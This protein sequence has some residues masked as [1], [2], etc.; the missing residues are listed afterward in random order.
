MINLGLIGSGLVSQICHLPSFVDD[1]RVKFVAISDLNQDILNKV[2]KKYSI[3]N[4]FTDYKVM[5]QKCKLDGVVLASNRNT[6]EEISEYILKKKINLFVEKPQSFSSK[7]AK[8]LIKLSNKN[9]VKYVVGYMKKYD[10]GIIFLKNY[11]KKK[12]GKIKSVYYENFLGDSY[13]NPFE[14]FRIKKKK[15]LSQKI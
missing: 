14:Y 5:L 10:N 7:V 11:L 8:K 13:Q 15:I 2:S 3:K 9:N 4:R 1:K 12:K 6:I